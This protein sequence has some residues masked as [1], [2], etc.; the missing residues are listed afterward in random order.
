MD[1]YYLEKQ[2]MGEV[3]EAI[4]VKEL[5]VEL[6]EHLSYTAHW[7]L[8]YCER[9]NTKLPD[10]DKLVLLIDRSRRL[11]NTMYGPYSRTPTTFYREMIMV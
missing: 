7:I 1:S 6:L 9:N 11:I 5:N 10:L 4:R 8:D 3:Q 2:L